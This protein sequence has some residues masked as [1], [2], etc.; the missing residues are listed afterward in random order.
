LTDFGSSPPPGAKN[1]NN[2]PFTPY[3][4][5]QVDPKTNA[6]S[7]SDFPPTFGPEGMVV[8]QTEKGSIPI[9]LLDTVMLVDL[10]L[11][12]LQEGKLIPVS[13]PLK[14]V[15]ST[16][17]GP[18][19]IRTRAFASDPD[20]NHSHFANWFLESNTV[21]WGT[22]RVWVSNGH[23]EPIYYIYRLDSSGNA[24]VYTQLTRSQAWNDL[25]PLL[26]S[27]QVVNVNDATFG[28]AYVN[29]W[30]ASHLFL[31]TQK[32]VQITTSGAR[33]I[34][35]IDPVLTALVTESGKYALSGSFAAQNDNGM[36][37]SIASS[38]MAT[39]SSVGF[40]RENPH[41]VVVSS[42]FTGVFYASDTKRLWRSLTPYLPHPVA[43]VS[44]VSI[45]KDTIYVSTE[46]RGVFRIALY[47]DIPLATYFVRPNAFLHPDVIT[48][49]MRSDGVP[50]ANVPV[51]LI[52]LDI[53]QELHLGATTDS[54]GRIVMKA[55]K[56]T[57]VI[58]FKFAGNK[59]AAPAQASFKY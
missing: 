9:P 8:V 48:Q 6:V 20:A 43:P 16:T 28:P 47:N 35:E 26:N 31:L 49:L 44:S 29:P 12:T 7:C 2:Q 56:P 58:H 13:G 27:A 22:K 10:P 52:I 46:G 25:G 11:Q 34:F 24:A 51:D 23:F 59:D 19:L 15:S 38:S 39:L 1:T 36:P 45:D 18:V 33:G 21:P 37:N 3:C 17:K 55:V 5:K 30:D 40:N 57:W 50:V 4:F 53:N 41:E 14:N 32:G 42:P 54:N